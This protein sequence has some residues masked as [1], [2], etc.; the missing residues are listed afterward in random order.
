MATKLPNGHY[1]NYQT[2][3]KL[4][5]GHKIYQICSFEIFRHTLKYTNIFNS[6]ALQNLPKLVFFGLKM[7][8]LATLLCSVTIIWWKKLRTKQAAVMPKAAGIFAT[9]VD[10]IKE[11]R[12]RAEVT[13]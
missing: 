2:A 11:R 9:S 3:T 12:S 5:N 10:A 6:K 8:H 7:C 4:P 13:K 1:V